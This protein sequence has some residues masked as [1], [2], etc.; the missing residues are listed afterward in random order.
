MRTMRRCCLVITR[1]AGPVK[2][3][4]PDVQK[5]WLLQQFLAG[6]CGDPGLPGDPQISS[7]PLASLVDLCSIIYLMRIR[8]SGPG[9]PREPRL[10]CAL[11]FCA[12]ERFGH[13][14]GGIGFALGRRP[15]LD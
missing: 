1:Y 11:D 5:P 3:F 4:R 6:S 12:G 9:Q 10:S 2:L 13:V 15:S 8:G 14:A 7:K